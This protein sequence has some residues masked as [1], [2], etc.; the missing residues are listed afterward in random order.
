[1]GIIGLIMIICAF[2][3][4]GPAR[5]VLMILGVLILLGSCA[6]P[7]YY[8]GGYHYRSYPHYYHYRHF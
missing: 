3:T 8:Y 4:R 6:G 7:R 5:V 1:M 2:A